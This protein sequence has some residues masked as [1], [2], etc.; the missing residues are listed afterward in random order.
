MVSKF[1]DKILSL[2]SSYTFYKIE[3]EKL[4]QKCKMLE[5]ENHFLRDDMKSLLS[6]QQELLER[7]D[8]DDLSRVSDAIMSTQEH[9]TKLDKENK[10][11]LESIDNRCMRI[12]KSSSYTNIKLDSKFDENRRFIEDELLNRQ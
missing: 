3:Y 10:Q 7:L 2:S 12:E 9:F 6:R 4:S 11:L 8:N 5:E 1:M